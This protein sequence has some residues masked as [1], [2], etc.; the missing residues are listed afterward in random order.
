M[1]ARLIDKGQ[2]KSIA[3]CLTDH[4]TLYPSLVF[5]ADSSHYACI[6]ITFTF[7]KVCRKTLFQCAMNASEQREKGI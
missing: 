1:L 7:T 4:G 6:I 5:C 3:L 2:T